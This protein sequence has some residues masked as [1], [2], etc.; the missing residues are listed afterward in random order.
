M[1]KVH[2]TA[3]SE[4]QIRAIA[5]GDRK[6]TQRIFDAFASLGQE[7]RPAGIKSL[8]PGFYRLR[9]GDYRIFYL[10][11]DDVETVVVSG[12]ERRNEATY[13]KIASHRQQAEQEASQ[14]RKGA[15]RK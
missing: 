10:V 2:L 8:L 11:A 12:I 13:K 14:I 1:Y 9:V 4:K 3:L 6:S 5:K 7:P 15:K